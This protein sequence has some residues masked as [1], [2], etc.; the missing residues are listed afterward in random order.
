MS[1]AARSAMSSEPEALSANQK[2]IDVHK[3]IIAMFQKMVSDMEAQA[4]GAK[5]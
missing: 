3:E 2:V 5:K 1:D 4:K